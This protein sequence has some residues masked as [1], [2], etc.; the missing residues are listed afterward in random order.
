MHFKTIQ[1]SAFKSLFEVLKDVL[2]DVNIIFTP[3]GIQILTLDNARTALID[4]TLNAENFE[5]YECPTVINAGIN[6][7]NMFKLL[8]VISNND[9]LEMNIISNDSVTIRVENADKHAKTEFKLHLLDIDDDR[10]QMPSPNVQYITTLPS[11]DFQRICRDMGN[12]SSEIT[13]TRRENKL[14]LACA[15]DF[16]QQTTELETPETVDDIS[17][18]TYSLKYINVFTK[19]TGMSSNMQIRQNTDSN[20]LILHYDVANLGY[21]N[22]YLASKIDEVD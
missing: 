5:E 1:A 7:V 16:A 22:F 20:F 10:I 4:L 18:G 9:T 21:L 15:G 3:E 6:M 19:A 13:I 8:K 12:I 17:E 14:T 11:T 2:N